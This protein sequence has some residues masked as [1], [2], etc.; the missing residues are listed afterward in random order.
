MYC[1]VNRI[2]YVCLGHA[3]SDL[4]AYIHTEPLDIEQGKKLYR[5]L[6]STSY[7]VHDTFNRQLSSFIHSSPK[8]N[9]I[10]ETLEQNDNDNS[11]I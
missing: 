1:A 11:A 4:K 9:D 6:P 8:I 2:L 10:F 7:Y 5:L 3:T